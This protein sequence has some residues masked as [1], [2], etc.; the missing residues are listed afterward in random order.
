MPSPI[1]V[2]GL[3]KTGTTALFY[4]IKNSFPNKIGKL[5]EYLGIKLHGEAV[6]DNWV[7]RVVR[8]K[9][10]GDW[11][12]WFLEEDIEYFRPIFR[13]FMERYEYPDDWGVNAKPGIRREHCSEYVKR[14]ALEYRVG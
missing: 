10:S 8:T 14:I 4:K 11:K 12:N 9:S 2:A 7:S 13:E 1:L 3:A 5:E 6:V